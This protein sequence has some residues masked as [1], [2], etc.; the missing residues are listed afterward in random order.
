[1]SSLK[2]T[3]CSSANRVG[4]IAVGFSKR[5]NFWYSSEGVFNSPELAI[6]DVIRWYEVDGAYAIKVSLSRKQMDLVEE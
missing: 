1:M 4:Y 2:K 5:D 3:G 6:E